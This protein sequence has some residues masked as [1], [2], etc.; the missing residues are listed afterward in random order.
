MVAG[1]AEIRLGQ[2]LDPLSLPVLFSMLGARQ[3]DEVIDESHRI[4]E[5]EPNFSPGYV[6][7]ALAY[8]E[9]GQF[10]QAVEA[11]EKAAKNRTDPTIKAIAAHVHGAKGNR[12]TSRET[13]H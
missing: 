10:E 4:L 2:A 6:A 5:R 9:K 7:A 13:A 12:S 1:R 8:R 3:F 11:I